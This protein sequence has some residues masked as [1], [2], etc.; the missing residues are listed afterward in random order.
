MSAIA[1]TDSASRAPLADESPRQPAPAASAAK[2][3][4]AEV[5][6]ALD[7]AEHG[8]ESFAHAYDRQ[9]SGKAGIQ[10]TMD[11]GRRAFNEGYGDDQLKNI[12]HTRDALSSLRQRVADGTT[13]AA[14]AKRELAQITSGFDNEAARVTA[15]QAD[16]AEMGKVVHGAG[17]IATV[18]MAG[19]GATA[20]SGGNVFIGFAAGMG[21]GSAYDALTVADQGSSAIAPKLDGN[22][23]VGGVVM[24]GIQ[25][26]QLDGGDWVRGGFGSLADAASGAFAG[27]G[28]VSA[29]AAQVGAQQVAL[30]SGQQAS[31]MA[32][33]NA[34]A[35]ANVL[36]GLAD[37][38][39][40]YGIRSVA[41]A[42]DP[43]LSTQQKEQQ[44]GQNTL[45]TARQ[46]PGQLA[47]GAVSSHLAVSRQLGNRAL[48]TGLQFGLD[49]T[50]NLAQTSLDNALCGKGFGVSR[51]DLAA[52]LVQTVPGT[53]QNLAQRVSPRQLQAQAD[54]QA[55]MHPYAG[56]AL[57]SVPAHAEGSRAVV[58]R[59][60]KVEFDGPQHDAVF[61]HTS[62]GQRSTHQMWQGEGKSVINARLD[63][64]D[65]IS[66][67]AH[68]Y[69]TFVHP[70]T[71]QCMVLAVDLTRTPAAA[72]RDK[73][74][75]NDLLQRADL[76]PAALAGEPP[77]GETPRS[78]VLPLIDET[79]TNVLPQRFADAHAL[80]VLKAASAGGRMLGITGAAALP[81]ASQ[82]AT[83]HSIGQA[84]EWMQHFLQGS[85]EPKIISAKQV[86]QAVPASTLRDPS[87]LFSVYEPT[88]TGLEARGA[89]AAKIA[90]QVNA[91][92]TEGAVEGLSRD[93]VV[94][95]TG[96]WYNALGSAHVSAVYKGRWSID[97]GDGSVRFQGERRWL[98]QDRYNWEVPEF[99]GKI[100]T[101]PA[102]GVPSAVV[103]L[104]PGSYQT[105]FKAYSESRQPEI[106][107]RV[108]VSDG[109]FG[110]LQMLEGGAQPFWTF[111]LG[112]PVAIDER[113]APA[114]RAT[115]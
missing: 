45:Q 94:V 29:K 103:K 105:A 82:R 71:E 113:W 57:S 3:A 52:T 2:P 61:L 18:T 98:V 8:V 81:A 72:Q 20:L 67:P 23:S 16:N 62:Q 60:Q 77:A 74:A 97:A 56:R 21:A 25:G 42:V 14:D 79:P 102:S 76:D 59:L 4:A 51:A 43:T 12:G 24:R 33:G 7:A 35:K 75:L 99:N 109:L 46:L 39:T 27:Q 17:R 92:A 50:T 69:R 63:N 32:L 55:T 22:Q 1:P 104:L 11:W 13:S 37:T 30:Q 87:D 26:E 66:A 80:L 41:I 5:R 34:A 83:A 100:T 85:G 6:T 114:A 108:A 95:T 47:F 90:A 44:F 68:L 31:R 73:A 93:K 70:L 10:K 40:R 84:S 107:D 106:I 64:D 38:G 115:P 28:M 96:G 36:T 78:N 112:A 19:L 86:A 91:G 101:T 88:E 54:G 15:A 9:A 53:A 89:L 111:G 110:H 49:G 58:G 65:S 48:D